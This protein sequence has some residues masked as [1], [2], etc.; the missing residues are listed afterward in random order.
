MA[1]ETNNAQMVAGIAWQGSLLAV[2]VLGQPIEREYTLADLLRRPEVTYAA[3]MTLPSRT[4]YREESSPR[5]A[6]P[7]VRPRPPCQA[8]IKT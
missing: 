1:A 6:I 4:R 3:L 2:R 7:L 5:T 8:W